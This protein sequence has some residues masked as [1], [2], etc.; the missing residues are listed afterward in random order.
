MLTAMLILSAQW[1]DGSTIS[2][3]HP[4]NIRARWKR[5]PPISLAPL[6][7]CE[8]AVKFDHGVQRLWPS[9]QQLQKASVTLES[10]HRY[11]LSLHKYTGTVSQQHSLT[12]NAI[13]D[14]SLGS[15]TRATCFSFPLTLRD[16]VF[17]VLCSTTS[18]AQ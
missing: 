6:F 11:P 5:I 12:V 14:D 13:V 15:I 4:H 2:V 7:A 17:I 16:A 18:Y 8:V 9:K 1:V 10:L 3:R